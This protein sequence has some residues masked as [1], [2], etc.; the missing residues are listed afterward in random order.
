ME[1]AQVRINLG[2]GVQNCPGWINYDRSRAALIGKLP[3]AR[4]LLKAIKPNALDWPPN[5]RVRDLTRGIPHPDGS[6]DAI[7]SSHMLEHVRPDDAQF[8][9][10]ECHRVL[11]PGGT[12]RVI[13]PDLR[14][15]TTAYLDGDRD[16]LRANG[17][18]LA[19]AY[20]RELLALGP[21]KG[22]P[23]E[24]L[25]RRALRTE[26]GGHKWMYDGESL[27]EHCRRAGFEDA[28]RV[29]FREGRDRETAQ[30]DTRS[31]FHVHVEAFKR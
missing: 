6:V 13:V 30:L 23:A 28:R 2:A 19:D 14:V 27:L 29:G 5:T 7:F 3:V 21:P 15:I 25:V 1:P 18:P 9:L 20:M 26:D 22:G 10:G 12:L 8:I 17:E 11:K 4:P 24:R 31:P 16:H